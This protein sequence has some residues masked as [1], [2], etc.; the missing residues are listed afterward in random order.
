MIVEVHDVA[1]DTWVTRVVGLRA[2]T[3][4][5]RFRTIWP[6]T[7]ETIAAG[8]ALKIHAIGV[9]DEDGHDEVDKSGYKCGGLLYFMEAL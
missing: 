7:A 6:E 8:C 1:T 5:E 2:V 4:G 9:A 3:K